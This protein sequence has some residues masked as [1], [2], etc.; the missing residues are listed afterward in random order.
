[1]TKALTLALVVS[2]L[3]CAACTHHLPPYDAAEQS[4]AQALATI[5]TLKRVDTPI[6]GTFRESLMHAKGVLIFPEVTRSR[7]SDRTEAGTGIFL[8]RLDS[9][10]WS[11]PAFYEIAGNNSSIR[12][13]L[14]SAQVVFVFASEASVRSVMAEQFHAPPDS[15]W[16]A[17]QSLAGTTLFTWQNNRLDVSGYGLVDN[18]YTQLMLPTGPVTRSETTNKAYYARGATPQQIL[19]QDRVF[20]LQAD[21]LRQALVLE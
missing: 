8:I 17:A 21:P 19:T 13:G 20:N 9:R 15:S 2:L 7:V 1:V 14:P 4:V 11:Y 10:T 3:C 18:R 6:G 5:E 12:L 16:T